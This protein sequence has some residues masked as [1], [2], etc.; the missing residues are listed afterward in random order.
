M[1]PW[2]FHGVD[3][4]PASPSVMA[5]VAPPVPD[6]DPDPEPDPPVDGA[7]VDV[8]DGVVVGVV[9]VAGA[10]VREAVPL[11]VGSVAAV[12][13]LA[14][15][16]GGP[17]VAVP[18]GGSV[19]DGSQVGPVTPPGGRGTVVPGSVVAGVG[20]V[21]PGMVVAGGVVVGAGGVVVGAGGVVVGAGGV[22]VGAG[23]AAASAVT[24]RASESA[25]HFPSGTPGATSRDA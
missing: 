6:P 21:V 16:E 12:V 3:L 2:L 23:G 8:R 10:G 11:V 13:E 17:D 14:D 22:V 24:T 4:K 5:H 18:E 25:A 1:A 15:R 7:V 9:V 19:G 20:A